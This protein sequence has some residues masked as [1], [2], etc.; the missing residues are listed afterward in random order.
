MNY[1][2]FPATLLALAATVVGGVAQN[3]T[4]FDRV[5]NANHIVWYGAN[6]RPYQVEVSPDLVSWG[7]IGP[8]YV[9][10][11]DLLGHT[12]NNNAPSLFYRVRDGAMRPGFDDVEF[13][14]NDDK[15]YP[16]CDE[17]SAT[18]QTVPIG[19]T[20]N[21]YG[22]SFSSCYVNTNG[23]IT[24]G[25]SLW[26][27]TPDALYELNNTKIIA[28][29]WADVDTRDSGSDMVRFSGQP[30]Q[31]DGHSAFG[32]TYR[33]VGYFNRWS[34][35][36]NSFQVILIDRSDIAQGD[37]D[38]EFNYNCI[39]WETGDAS[40][41]YLG[42]GGF[43]ARVGVSS[44]HG[45]CLEYQGSGETLEFLDADPTSGVPNYQSGLIYQTL[46]SG[47]PGRIRIPFRNGQPPASFT[48]NAGP[49]QIL[50][51]TSGGSF[52]LA[53]TT[54]PTP[55]SG[56]TYEWSQ[57]DGPSDAAFSSTTILNPTVTITE[58]GAF[59][60]KLTATKP[61][62]FNEIVSDEVAVTH[63]GEFDVYGGYYSF[64]SPDSLEVQ[65]DQAA[66]S[67]TGDQ[68][69][70]VKWTQ[71]GGD[72]ASIDNDTL[73]QPTVTLPGPGYYTFRMVVTTSHNPPF[74][75]TEYATIDYAEQ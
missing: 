28:P 70:T 32:V 14:R 68:Q 16:D 3:T 17:V 55:V 18:P 8:V 38:V 36:L 6:L 39:I 19:F 74:T 15:T 9:G 57:I 53:G 5:G 40:S 69:L 46:N 13:G 42:Y 22:E 72:Q 10:A 29:F 45:N 61:G 12:D 43:P 67:F 64:A 7:E 49:D 26:K 27:Y 24:F 48:V 65:L 59:K 66:A 37:F 30:G 33:N 41:G 54:D 50:D 25:E 11:D 73:L 35:K 1:S 75:T 71:I 56:A 47:I 21:F 23:N 63:P 2:Y 58:P 20:V 4:I 44:G 62:S 31:V 60:F 34:D 52:D 51:V